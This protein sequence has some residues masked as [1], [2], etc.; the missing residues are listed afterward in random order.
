MNFELIDI[1]YFTV[2]LAG[3]F[4]AILSEEIGGKQ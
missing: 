4:W 2:I 3:F 1:L